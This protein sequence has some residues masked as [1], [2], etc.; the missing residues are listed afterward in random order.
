MT[1]IF[2]KGYAEVAP[3][4]LKEKEECWYLS[5]F[6]VYHP[7]KTNQLRGV[8]DSAAQFD[9]ISLNNVLDQIQKTVYW[10]FS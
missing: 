5:I 10:E 7:K 8:F 1:S 3:P 4:P 9:G 6:G 2:E